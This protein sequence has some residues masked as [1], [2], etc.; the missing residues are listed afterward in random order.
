SLDSAIRAY[1]KA[2]RR[3]LFPNPDKL[4]TCKFSMGKVSIRMKAIS[5][6]VNLSKE[7]EVKLV[8]VLKKKSRKEAVYAAW[9]RQT[10]TLLPDVM[11]T[12]LD[13]LKKLGDTE[14]A[15][16]ADNPVTL[17]KMALGDSKEKIAVFELSGGGDTFS[18]SPNKVDL[19]K[20]A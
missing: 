16:D 9:Y 7:N 13:L 3:K 18:I 2:N 20:A 8:A 5:L 6:K 15:G 11:K 12:R 1:D 14:K 17:V 4:K 10:I 19:K